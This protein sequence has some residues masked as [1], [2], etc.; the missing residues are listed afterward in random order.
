MII[1]ILYLSTYSQ[2]NRE[3]HLLF[4]LPLSQTL[5]TKNLSSPMAITIQV[6]KEHQIFDSRGNST[7]EVRFL[8]SH[9]PDLCVFVDSVLQ[10][11]LFRIKNLCVSMTI[12]HKGFVND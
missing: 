11:V 10:T 12:V 5:E 4:S 7:I 6:I 9:V 2:K 3:L 1:D 8:N